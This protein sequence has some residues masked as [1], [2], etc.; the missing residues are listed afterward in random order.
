[1]VP[2][3]GILGSVSPDLQCTLQALVNG[4]CVPLFA[5]TPCQAASHT[6]ESLRE[7]LKLNRG[8]RPNVM[9]S[10]FIPLFVR[11]YICVGFCIFRGNLVPLK[12]QG[13]EHGRNS[14]NVWWRNTAL[15]VRVNRFCYLGISSLRRNWDLKKGLSWAQTPITATL[16]PRL[17]KIPCRSMSSFLEYV[18]SVIFMPVC[19]LGWFWT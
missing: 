1:M 14:E 19:D 13:Q 11:A 9:S 3:S 6:H 12:A 2:S 17:W 5:V 16:L 8:S 15:G 10:N 4:R 7:Y 18:F